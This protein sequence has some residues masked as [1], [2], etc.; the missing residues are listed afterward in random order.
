M[1][2]NH[3]ALKIQGSQTT[4][5][6]FTKRSTGLNKPLEL[7]M[8]VLK[9]FLIKNGFTIGKADSTLFTRKVDNELF[10]C[11]I[12]VDDII[13]G[14]TNEKF[15]EE[16]SKVMTNRFEMSMM[17]ELKYFL[18]F[19]VKQL[20]KV[21]FYAKPNIHKTCSRSLAWKRQSTPRL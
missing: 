9:I 2:S 16:F 15:C 1:W 13:F 5:I 6:Y 3:R 8:I 12:Y 17:G 14:S 19:Q 4:S 7:G 18:G 21:P 20:R 11:Q 10:V